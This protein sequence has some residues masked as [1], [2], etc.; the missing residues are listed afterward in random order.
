L[1]HR[2]LAAIYAIAFLSLALQIKGLVG[3]NG[4]LPANEF[5]NWIRGQAASQS[6]LYVPTIF[7][8]NPS[9][10]ALQFV[11]YAG[12][13][14][15]IILFIGFQSSIIWFVLWVL[16]LSLSGV[17]QDFLGFQ[18]D[19][20]LLEAGLLMVFL[21]PSL[22]ASPRKKLKYVKVVLWM[23]WWLLFRL[24]FSSGFAK[25]ASGDTT[26]RDLTALNY[27]YE[28]QPLPTILSWYAHLLP[29][30][31]QKFSVVG[32]FA[33][34][35]L[36]PFLIFAPRFFRQIAFWTLVALQ[37]SIA[38]T[39]N[40]TFFNFLSIALCLL[41]LDDVWWRR[42][43]ESP[44]SGVQ[45]PGRFVAYPICAV[46]FVLSIL[47]MSIT[48]G[49]QRILPPAALQFISYSEPFRSVNRY[50]LFAVMTTRRAEIIVEGSNDQTVWL[51]YEFKY[52][53]DRL[54]KSLKFVEPFQPR[55]D[56]Q[57]W[58]AALSTYRN[59]PWFVNFCARLLQG[60]PEVLSLLEKN[61]FPSKPPK[62]IRA[63][64]YDYHFSNYSDH[65]KTGN[66]WTRT[67]A[68]IYCPVMSLR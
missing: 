13:A 48:L 2:I 39:G 49:F 16:Y 62:F 50:G 66:W 67:E 12:I 3:Q 61:P 25:L 47:Q 20:L 65:Q 15:S 8:W 19:I 9:D 51:P 64:L 68:G 43:E 34:E 36:M 59:N 21:V 63:V 35:L 27:H 54:N 60:S 6:F 30:W 53:P 1:F 55:L 38:L 44:G 17:C 7:W 14:L 33:I 11:C 24:M 26:W 57:M 45:S 40:Y 32:M 52:K 18:W 56:W 31:F 22:M 10:F 58:F 28:T 5:L 29:Q 46:L 4:I 23:F 37:I 41:L 42:K